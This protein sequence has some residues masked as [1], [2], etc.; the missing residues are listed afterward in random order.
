MTPFPF[1]GFFIM[2]ILQIRY[3]LQFMSAEIRFI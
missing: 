1:I 2:R 3:S